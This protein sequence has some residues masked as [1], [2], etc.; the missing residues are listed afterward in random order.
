MTAT[1]RRV[2][3]EICTAAAPARLREGTREVRHDPS[4][5]TGRSA[6]NLNTLFRTGCRGPPLGSGC[7]VYEIAVTSQG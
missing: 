3:G 6:R 4:V 2:S 7:Q 5:N 1:G